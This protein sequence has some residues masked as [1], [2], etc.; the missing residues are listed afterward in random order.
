MCERLNDKNA[1]MIAKANVLQHFPVVGVLEMFNSTLK[2][3]ESKLPQY[4][5]GASNISRQDYLK[6]YDE[7]NMYNE[8]E[9]KVELSDKAFQI[10]KRK[11]SHEIE[12]YDFCVQRLKQQLKNVPL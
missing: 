12:F 8:K 6:A 4:F 7:E 5:L 3:L 10:V 9:T 1:L 11:V 2:V